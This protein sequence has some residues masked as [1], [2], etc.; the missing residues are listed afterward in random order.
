MS[1]KDSTRCK[2]VTYEIQGEWILS[3]D[4]DEVTP[5]GGVSGCSNKAVSS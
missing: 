4:G 2:I 1:V 5:F 3:P